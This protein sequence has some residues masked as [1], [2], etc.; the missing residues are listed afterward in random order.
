MALSASP[1]IAGG[2]IA[3]YRMC[4][5]S[6]TAD[7]TV[8]QAG[9]ALIPIVGVSGSGTKS[10]SSAN[11]AESGDPVTFQPGPYV[12]IEAGAA[13]TRGAT[14]QPDSSGRAITA[15]TTATGAGVQVCQPFVA[16]QSAAAAGDKIWCTPA[17]GMTAYN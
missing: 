7:N 3:P 9:S 2:T 10:A 6:N 1:F 15:V 12:Q 11:H 8:T 13:I 4:T 16:C 17:L 5:V 14:L